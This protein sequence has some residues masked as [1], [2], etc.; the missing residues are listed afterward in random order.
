MTYKS[1]LLTSLLFIF[2]HLNLLKAEG[3]IAGTLVKTKYGYLPIEQLT[4]GNDIIAHEYND[5][6]EEQSITAITQYKTNQLIKINI[7]NITIFTAPDQKFYSYNQNKWIFAHELTTSDTLM[8]S[9]GKAITIDAIT[10][11]NEQQTMY[12]ISLANSHT[13]YI[14]SENILVHNFIN[15]FITFPLLVRPIVEIVKVGLTIGG[16]FLAAHCATKIAKKNRNTPNDAIQ[17]HNTIV[18]GGGWQDPEDN[19][20][21]H[22]HGIYEKSPYHHSKSKGKKS[23][24]PRNGQRCLDYSLP[25]EGTQRISIEND[26]F[27]VLK[28]TSP[29]KFH[30]YIVTWK[31]LEGSMQSMLI[32]NGFVTKSGKILKQITEIILT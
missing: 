6:L 2:A 30:G 28:Y 8:N 27:V 18:S 25:T 13:F 1:L 24:C 10:I 3:F 23:P 26:N 31:Q 22:P 32:K 9:H 21:K 11:I 20:K 15:V 29:G 12:S 7:N 5:V 17:N 4:I 14:S 19:N 16:T